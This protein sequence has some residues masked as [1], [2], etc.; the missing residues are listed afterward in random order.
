SIILSGGDSIWK[1]M[2]T[3]FIKCGIWALLVLEYP[4]IVEELRDFFLDAGSAAGGGG[5]GVAMLLDPSAI[6]D[7]GCAATLP[8]WEMLEA[9]E[10]PIFSG[11]SPSAFGSALVIL[12]CGLAILLLYYVIAI[13]L[14]LATV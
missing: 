12:V 7:L 13:A 5:V 6:A 10:Q 8:I 14:F 1:H 3:K 11:F 9:Q 4:L 2:L